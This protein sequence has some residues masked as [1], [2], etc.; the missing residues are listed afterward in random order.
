M[1]APSP[2]Y[3]LHLTIDAYGA[4]PSKLADPGL[5]FETLDALPALI[6]MQKIG[7]P[8]MAQFKEADKAGVSGIIMI[9]ESHISIHT[10]EKKDCFFM[11]VFSCKHFDHEVVV[12][13][14][15]RVFGAT[16]MEINLVERGKRFPAENLHA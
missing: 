14:V 13:H 11:D 2:S 5:L 15:K 4:D 9:V 6:G 8:Q 3:G 7:P 10:Y 16:D 12:E 1:T